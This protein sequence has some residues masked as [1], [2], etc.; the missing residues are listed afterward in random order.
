MCY[1]ADIVNFVSC[2]VVKYVNVHDDLSD[3]GN[4]TCYF[5]WCETLLGLT[6]GELVNLNF[7]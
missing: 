3:K 6:N 1:V 4:V 5:S 2:C 7:G